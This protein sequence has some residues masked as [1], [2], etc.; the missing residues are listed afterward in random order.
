MLCGQQLNFIRLAEQPIC[1][2]A[3]G[4]AWT[5]AVDMDPVWSA[6]QSSR[7]R[8][9]NHRTFRC[10]IRRYV[11]PTNKTKN[12]CRADDPSTIPRRMRLLLHHLSSRIF[13]AQ[14]DSSDV[15]IVCGIPHLNRTIPDRCGFEAFE[16]Y[17]GVVDLRTDGW[18]GQL[19]SQTFATWNL[20]SR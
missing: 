6:V 10:T 19:V 1:H 2:C 8:E 3:L 11:L 9:I 14:E 18:K 5:D 16:A 17:P 20:G 13:H 4:E 7:L 15:D 12:G